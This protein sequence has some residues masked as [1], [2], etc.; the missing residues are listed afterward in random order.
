MGPTPRAPLATSATSLP[1][2]RVA[3]DIVGPLPVA[4]HGNQYKLVLADYFKKWADAF[5]MPNQEAG[6]VANLLG[7]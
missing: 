1:F 4:N 3:L 2:E 6:T 5:H 7:N